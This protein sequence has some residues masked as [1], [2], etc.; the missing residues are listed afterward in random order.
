MLNERYLLSINVLTTTYHCICMYRTNL[1]ARKSK[2]HKL[3]GVARILYHLV[4]TQDLTVQNE[5][6]P[7]PT[8]LVYTLRKVSTVKKHTNNNIPL[9]LHV[10]NTV[11]CIYYLF[12]NQDLSRPLWPRRQHEQTILY[13]YVCMCVCVCIVPAVFSAFYCSIKQVKNIHFHF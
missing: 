4:N 12:S 9:Y 13:Y 6:K 5:H 7:Q 8:M 3:N 11:T 1:D 2:W 10:Q